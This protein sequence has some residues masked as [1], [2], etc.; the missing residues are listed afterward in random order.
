MKTGALLILHTYADGRNFSGD[1]QG[2]A[3]KQGLGQAGETVNLSTDHRETEIN[4]LD[5][6]QRTLENFS[7]HQWRISVGQIA[8]PVLCI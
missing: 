2:E 1:Y 4:T 8:L 7:V 3:D 5:G 6:L